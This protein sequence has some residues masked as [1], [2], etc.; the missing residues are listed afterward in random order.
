MF[1]GCSS[2]ENLDLSSFDTFS[3]MN[4]EM[5][6]YECASLTSLE[7]SNFKTTNANNLKFMF[8]KCSSLTSLNLPY[9]DTSYI[10]EENLSSMFDECTKLNLY[11]NPKKCQNLFSIIPEYVTVYNITEK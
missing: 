1:Y 6:F 2:L 8:Y 10:S 9:F 11:I 5:L 4:M 7:I 3:V